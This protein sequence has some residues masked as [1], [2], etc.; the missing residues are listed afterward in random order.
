MIYNLYKCKVHTFKVMKAMFLG[1]LLLPSLKYIYNKR[2]YHLKI[3]TIGI[4][5]L[6]KSR[7]IFLYSSC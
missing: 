6:P 4:L 2:D 3:S 5:L 1:R 7:G